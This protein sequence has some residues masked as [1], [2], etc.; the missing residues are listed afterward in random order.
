MDDSKKKSAQ[1]RYHD[2][3]SHMTLRISKDDMRQLDDAAALAGQS[4]TAYILQA[5]RERME[6][7]DAPAGRF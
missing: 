5:I 6:R 3:L 2:K 1:D 7:D 4:R